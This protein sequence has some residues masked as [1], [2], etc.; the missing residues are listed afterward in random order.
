MTLSWGHV[1][2]RSRWLD[3]IMRRRATDVLRKSRLS[4]H[5]PQSGLLLDVG[6]GTGHIAEAVL[7]D[8][9]RR[10][11]VT[12]DLWLPSPMLRRRLAA[13]GSFI[14]KASGVQLP[15][16]DA[17]FDGAWVAF[18]LHHMEP[19]AQL[20]AIRELSRVVKAGG[21]LVVIEDTPRDADEART[22]LSADRALNLERR[23][24]PHHYRAPDE[25]H[26]TLRNAGFRIQKRISFT[27][28]FPRLSSK[29]IPHT[30]F[31]CRG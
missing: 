16:K 23:S 11:C 1:L 30:A 18:V 13:R 19:D 24:A 27:R 22:V 29:K 10:C 15:F 4:Q 6:G 2:H 25:W 31:I 7:T 26:A 3:P 12:T 28:V 9:P 21:T 20:S 5:L 8:S 14:V 17:S